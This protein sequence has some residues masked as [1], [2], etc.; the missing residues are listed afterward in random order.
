M[1]NNVNHHNLIY[2]CQTSTILT[3]V[4]LLFGASHLIWKQREVIWN[5]C[6]VSSTCCSCVDRSLKY[7]PDGLGLCYPRLPFFRALVC[8][9]WSSVNLASHLWRTGLDHVLRDEFPQSVLNST[10]RHVPPLCSEP[11]P[12]RERR[13]ARTVKQPQLCCVS[14]SFD[15]FDWEHNMGV[16]EVHLALIGRCQFDL[17]WG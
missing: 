7:N 1:E 10:H 8:F 13:G 3:C 12:M 15:V 16:K 4:K 11:G 17:N 14:V 9:A 5:E 6:H 2:V